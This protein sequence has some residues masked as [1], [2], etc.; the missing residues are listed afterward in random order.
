M[1][2][3]LSAR[4]RITMSTG[5]CMGILCHGVCTTTYPLMSAKPKSWC[6]P[7][8]VSGRTHPRKFDGINGKWKKHYNDGL[9]LQV[10]WP[11]L[12]NN[13]TW[14][15]HTDVMIKK[16]G[17]EIYFLRHLRRF[18]NSRMILDSLQKS[19]M[20]T[21]Q[22]GMAAVLILTTCTCRDWWKQPTSSLLSIQSIFTVRY[23][24]ETESIVKGA[25]HHGHSTTYLL[26][27]GRRYRNLKAQTSR[28]KNN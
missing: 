10:P 20:G 11:P 23:T 21:S 3:L 5:K 22:P 2:P 28:L 25:C 17:Q 15:L 24:R 13:L 8:V 16:V 6:W 19:L 9:Q 14:P 18:S 26:P 12:T 1:K 27:Y 7:K 4:S